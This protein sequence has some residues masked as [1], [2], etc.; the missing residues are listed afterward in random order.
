M[1][2]KSNIVEQRG[3]P[4]KEFIGTVE[5]IFK[6]EFIQQ[7]V[8]SRENFGVYDL[9]VSQMG[10]DDLLNYSDEVDELNPGTYTKTPVVILNMT[11][12]NIDGDRAR[13][14]QHI[15]NLYGKENLPLIFIFANIN[16]HLYELP[17]TGKV[18]IEYT[19]QMMSVLQGVDNPVREVLGNKVAFIV[20]FKNPT[21]SLIVN[22]FLNLANSPLFN[23]RV[24]FSFINANQI[25]KILATKT[26]KEEKGES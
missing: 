13:A 20:D 3:G 4:N 5:N 17:E 22:V 19:R 6:E 25:R 16:K 1:E 10:L 26:K 8:G 15:I 9:Y 23:L 18:N 7:F 24:H 11:A 14:M 2:N 12:D 21:V